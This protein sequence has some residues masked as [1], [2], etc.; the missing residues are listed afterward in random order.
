MGLEVSKPMG[1]AGAPT[2]LGICIDSKDR[3]TT[4]PSTIAALVRSIQD[5]LGAEPD[6]S[7][8]NG[9]IDA[10]HQNAIQTTG[11]LATEDEL[12][13]FTGS[14]ARVISKAPNIRNH[15]AV[16]R[17]AVPECFLGESFRAY[18]AAAALRRQRQSEVEQRTD[19]E[20]TQRQ[21]EAA[22][23]EARYALWAQVSEAHKDDRGYD[24]QAIA[25]DPNLDEQGREQAKRLI[26]R[27]G[28]YTR[29]GL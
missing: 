9:I 26:E 23:A 14:K 3:Q 15:L 27:L 1:S 28:R 29:S 21:R 11:A 10:C 24:M 8:L 25:N 12:L 6:T 17:K 19:A 5:A 13:Y 7:L 4:S 20:Q 18:R 22:A 2:I 16:L